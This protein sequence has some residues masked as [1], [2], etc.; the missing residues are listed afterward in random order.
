VNLFARPLR[1][2]A[3][4]PQARRLH[5]ALFLIVL[6]CALVWIVPPAGAVVTSIEGKTFGVSPRPG[7]KFKAGGYSEEGYFPEGPPSPFTFANASGN[8]VLHYSRTYVIYWDPTDHYHGD[9]QK[10]IDKYMQ[11][12][13]AASGS[14]TTYAVD[15]QYT[16]KSNH[17]ASYLTSFHGAYTDT[18]AYPVNGC[19][20]PNP[21]LIFDNIGPG[22]EPVCLSATQIGAEVESFVKSHGLPTGLGNTYYLLTPPAVAVC[23][24]KGGP[25][26]HCS[27]YEGEASFEEE[28]YDHSFCSYHAAINPGG[29]PGGDAN[30]IAYGVIPWTA[31]GFADGHL[32][33]VDRRAGWECQDGGYDPSSKPAGKPEEKK[34][35]SKKEIEEREEL[36]A[37][38]K[39]QQEN[40]E[41][42]EGPHE[43]EPNQ[44]P[45]PT[46]DGSCDYGLADLIINQ[47][48]IQQQDIVINPLLN[49][50]QDSVHAEASDECRYGLYE[51][52]WFAPIAGGTVAASPETQ[53]GTLFNQV[54]GTDHY[55]VN[56]AFN[57]AG[58]LLPYPGIP[59]PMGIR[60]EPSFT[61]PNPVNSGEVVGF[62]G[63]ESDIT[64]NANSNFP[65]GGA[66]KPNYATYTWN[67]GD[68]SPVTT[69]FA[70]GAPA[71]STPWLSP[72]AASVFHSFAYGGTYNVTLTVTDV[73][74]NVAT[75]SSPVTVVGPPPPAPGGSGS[76]A[77]GSGA[78]GSGST[79]GSSGTLPAPVL[80][81]A[82]V[83]RS[84]R[85]VS[86]KGLVV[87]YSVNEQ[88]AGH[89]DVLLNRSL[90]RRLGIGGVP[91]TG[92][93]AGTAPQ[94]VIAKAI[95]V[96]TAGGRSTVTISLSKRTAQ[97]LSRLHKVS[98]ML[99]ATV[100]NAEPL[101]PVTT[102]VVSAFALG[103]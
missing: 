94:V 74:G 58:L 32:F 85:N 2:L 90:A 17:P 5:G 49:A 92:L 88:V 68:G 51:E 19:E 91:A 96:T 6:A 4:R 63:M 102:T 43:Q 62:D 41:K 53:A 60:L 3:R 15:E 79:P 48:A 9:W 76:G 95:L 80:S 23:L 82:V 33:S 10:L 70:P 35:K 66:P 73:G 42:L 22:G 21:F 87:R 101:H 89:F 36:N 18:T 40:A 56:S 103:R 59:C 77:G 34:A 50:W 37:E 97:H 29:L 75:V 65:G 13:G 54:L 71:C 57:L 81:Y 16:D 8:P 12:V 69:G 1:P 98:L 30:T 47:I 55:Y 31:G 28:S 72:C 7:Q 14:F 64:L 38:K 52:P 93:P 86:R 26:G 46:S 27:D 78:G 99:R 100:R 44:E 84:L 24:D 45:C 20:D 61:A 83:S 67:F 25:T 39:A 11:D